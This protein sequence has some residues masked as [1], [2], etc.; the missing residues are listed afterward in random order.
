MKINSK[1][2]YSLFT[3]FILIVIIIVALL[4]IGMISVESTT[5][6]SI[7]ISQAQSMQE[8]GS[9]KRIIFSCLENKSL[10][11]I[12]SADNN[13]C[14][15]KNIKGYKI[16]QLN[17]FSCKSTFTKEFGSNENCSSRFSYFYSL[18]GYDAQK[19]LA[20]VMICIG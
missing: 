6:S 3:S 11:D 14:V 1:G 10:D 13:Y 7:F 4:F 9:A 16:E 18:Q 5:S 8:V 15:P 17:F 19:C 12:M 2:I 20:R